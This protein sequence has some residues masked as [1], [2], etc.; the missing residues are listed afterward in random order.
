LIEFRRQVLLSALKL[1]DFWVVTGSFLLSLIAAYAR[2]GSSFAQLLAVR[3]KLGNLLIL[4]ATLATW[5]LIFLLSGMYDSKRLASRRKEAVDALRATTLCTGF[6]ALITLLFHVSLISPRV[7]FVFWALSTACVIFGRLILRLC[8]AFIRRHGRNLRQILILGTNERA[9]GFASYLEARPDLGYRILGFVDE[10]WQGTEDFRE[11]GRP[12][13]CNLTALP[14][15]LRHNVVDE[16][17]N[18]LPL[19]SSYEHAS[20]VANLCETHGILLRLQSSIFDSKKVRAQRRDFAETDLAISHPVPHEGLPMVA[21]RLLDIVGSAILLFLLSPLLLIVSALIKLTSP[22]PVLFLQERIGYNKRRF[23]IYK[24]RTMVPNAEK[25][26]AKLEHLNE[27]SGPVFKI[28]NDPRIT[29][30]GKF[31]RRTS[32]DELPQLLNVLKGEMSLVGP[33]PLPVRDYQGFNQDWHRRRFAIRPGLT[34]LWQVNGRSS[35]TFE[36]WMEL[37]LQYM[38]EWSLWL[39]FK[40]LLRTIPAVL[41]GSGAA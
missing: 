7:I 4:L 14:E 33:R 11:S 25:I 22:G 3:V 6:L 21:K 9:L 26:M 24:F 40:I 35:I 10:E 15:Y 32:I 28:K 5:Y 19:R 1:F 34:C 29:P 23:R 39:D 31:L 37:D 41:K 18:Y 38:D 12:L 27:V 36:Q 17:A 16:V 2:T 30:I 13:A 20:Q 8:L